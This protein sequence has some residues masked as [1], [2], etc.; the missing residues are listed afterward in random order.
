[1]FLCRSKQW[2]P[3]WG[4][5]FDAERVALLTTIYSRVI[6]DDFVMFL[7]P[8]VEIA[9]VRGEIRA[10]IDSNAAA[11]WLARL[12]FSLYTTP[13]PS[14]DLDDPEVTRQFVAEFAL[15]GLQGPPRPQA[16]LASTSASI[17]AMLDASQG[18]VQT[19]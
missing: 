14:R 19:E 12:L 6:M 5:A 3:L 9:R 15:A 10:D 17:A 16:G 4:Q 18:R 8:Y 2:V 7:A 13:S 11:E 1:V